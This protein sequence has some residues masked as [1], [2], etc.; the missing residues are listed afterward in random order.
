MR[1]LKII[2]IGSADSKEKFCQEAIDY[3]AQMQSQFDTVTVVKHCKAHAKSPC[4]HIIDE[5]NQLTKDCD[6]SNELLEYLGKMIH[7]NK[8]YILKD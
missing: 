2:L 8:G 1:P 5:Q 3:Q 4:L 7:E 6:K